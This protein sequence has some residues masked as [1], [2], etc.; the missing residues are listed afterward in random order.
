MIQN[1]LEGIVSRIKTVFIYPEYII[2]NIYFNPVQEVEPNSFVLNLLNYQRRMEMND[3]V[4]CVLDWNFYYIPETKMEFHFDG[5]DT[6]LTQMKIFEVAQQYMRVIPVKGFYNM[7]TQEND[8][9]YI[10]PTYDWYTTMMNDIVYCFFSM[11]L[12]V[13]DVEE[14]IETIQRWKLE[15]Q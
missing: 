9:T 11:E 4:D 7:E 2:N 12:R 8:R 3:V 1:L 6:I 14:D 13:H 10:I 15:I 5:Y